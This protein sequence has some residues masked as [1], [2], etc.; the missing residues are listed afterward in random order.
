MEQFSPYDLL[1]YGTYSY[2]LTVTIFIGCSLLVLNILIFAKVYRKKDRSRADLDRKTQDNKL[3]PTTSVLVDM[4]RDSVLHKSPSQ[5]SLQKTC[6]TLPHHLGM[7]PAS[8]DNPPN[9]SVHQ[10]L[11]IT[12]P[13]VENQPLLHTYQHSFTRHNTTGSFKVPSTAIGEMRVWRSHICLDFVSSYILLFII[14]Q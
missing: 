11:A 12:R 7:V 13:L 9:G 3:L 10:Y 4:G 6:N 2:A 1:G 14:F 8:R 5:H